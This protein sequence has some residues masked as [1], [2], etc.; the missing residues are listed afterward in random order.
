MNNNNVKI[1]KYYVIAN[2]KMNKTYNE[3]IK[4]FQNYLKLF[5]NIL[6]PNNIKIVF[7]IP[8]TNLSFLNSL[9]I[10]Q[11]KNI[12]YIGAQNLYPSSFGSYTGEISSMMLKELNVKYI[13]LGH[14]E[15]RVFFGENN[16]F[17]NNKVLHTLENNM[18]P[19]LC[20]GENSK[21]F[22]E[23]KTIQVLE[24]QIFKGLENVKLNYINN[25]IIAYEPI[26]SIGTGLQANKYILKEISFK[27]KKILNK[28]FNTNKAYNIPIIYGGS[29]KPD[30]KKLNDIFSIKQ[31]NGCLI[32]NSSLDPICFTQILSLINDILY[33][34][35]DLNPHDPKINGF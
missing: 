34:E 1:K 23:K 27:I 6:L 11:K 24:E 28:L 21:E 25:I 18:N 8:F 10:K 19:I 5:K 13:I 26:W 4:Y 35:R 14:S 17:I 9:F 33:P 31:L 2:F 29:I 15:R 22:Q 20:I 16:K 12:F 32:G 3:T 30:K 7:C